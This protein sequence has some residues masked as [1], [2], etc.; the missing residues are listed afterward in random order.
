MPQKTATVGSKAGLH[1]RPAS[2]F[3]KAAAAQPMAISIAK[4]DTPQESFDAASIL[5]LM[6]LGAEYGHEVVLTAE[7]EGAEAALQEL[8]ETLETELDT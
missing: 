4:A 2:V 1:A 3:V 6:A 7:G 8:A 5:G